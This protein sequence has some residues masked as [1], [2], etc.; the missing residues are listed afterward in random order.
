MH[1]DKFTF[2]VVKLLRLVAPV[3]SLLKME[4]AWT[5]ETSVSYYNTTQRHNPEDLDFNLYS[6]LS[7]NRDIRF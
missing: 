1:R 7:F 4:A 3:T 2:I 5:S 6:R